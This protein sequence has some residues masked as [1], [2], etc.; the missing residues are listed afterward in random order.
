VRQRTNTSDMIFPVAKMVSYFSHLMRLLSGDL[1]LTGTPEGIRRMEIG[2][3]RALTIQ[4]I[5]TLAT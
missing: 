4:C 5:G 3:T 2:E 1:I